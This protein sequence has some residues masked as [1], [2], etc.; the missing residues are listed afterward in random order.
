MIVIIHLLLT[1]DRRPNKSLEPT[2]V[3]A[4]SSAARFTSRFAGGSVLGR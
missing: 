1:D 4:G 3:G 2:G